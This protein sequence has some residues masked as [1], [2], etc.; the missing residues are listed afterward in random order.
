M[1]LALG[2]TSEQIDDEEERAKAERRQFLRVRMEQPGRLFLPHT[3]QE[4]ACQV[5][6]LSPGGAQVVSEMVPPDEEQVILYV[7][8][9]GRFEGK[10]IH[11]DDGTF[12]V[13]FH[14]S[15]VKRDKIAEQLTL[16]MN[17][18]L[19]GDAANKRYE[20]EP[21]KGLSRFTRANGDV[22]SCEILDL[23]L[24][25]VSLK[26]HVRPPLGEV[27]LIGQTAGRVTRHHQNGIAIEFINSHGEKPANSEPPPPVNPFTVIA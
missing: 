22:V 15:D 27:V 4:A 12:G 21:A 13:R 19:T 6:D 24:G 9:F 11:P 8:G 10:V 3:N 17:K 26:T 5:V 7:D 23:S 14:C 2:M 20:H 16:Y 18:D 1:S 25:G